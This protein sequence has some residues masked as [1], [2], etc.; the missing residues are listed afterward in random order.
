[1]GKTETLHSVA[2]YHF[3]V[4]HAL[5]PIYGH[6]FFLRTATVNLGSRAKPAFFTFWG[7]NGGWMLAPYITLT[8][9]NVSLLDEMNKQAA[10]RS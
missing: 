9:E 6:W 1:M 4:K 7:I 10:S 5:P 2:L 8:V 3:A